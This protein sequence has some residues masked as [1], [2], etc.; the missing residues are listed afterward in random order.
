[1]V[2]REHPGRRREREP[3]LA[4]LELDRTLAR[5]RSRLGRE[6]VVHLSQYRPSHPVRGRRPPAWLVGIHRSARLTPWIPGSAQ[7]PGA[8]PDPGAPPTRAARTTLTT[9]RTR[10]HPAG[11]T[12]PP[13]TDRA[14]RPGSRDPGS[15]HH[16]TG[17]Y[18]PGA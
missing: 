4:H 2:G 18:R 1:P 17:P 8:C 13:P 14:G 3:V 16:P 6:V 15:S 7:T 10:R 5:G 9:S 12:A 11:G